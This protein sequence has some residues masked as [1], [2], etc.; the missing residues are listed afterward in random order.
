MRIVILKAGT[1]N[2]A[3][4]HAHVLAAGDLLETGHEYGQN[5]VEDG[6]A[7]P[8]GYAVDENLPAEIAVSAETVEAEPVEAA[9]EIEPS[10]DTLPSEP[11]TI[12]LADGVDEMEA[13]LAGKTL[14][15]RK[16]R[17]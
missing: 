3:Q 5:L 1:Y 16:T 8:I 4:H 15:R 11:Q 9:R 7:N 14:S 2:D 6:Y 12:D 17:K 13:S 10:G